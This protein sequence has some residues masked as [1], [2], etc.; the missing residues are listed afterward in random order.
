MHAG[1]EFAPECDSGSAQDRTRFELM[2]ELGL[3]QIDFGVTCS[4]LGRLE[5]D[6]GLQ[7]G[8]SGCVLRQGGLGG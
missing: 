7:R 1:F 8:C 5:Y 2:V 3:L 4:S 6:V